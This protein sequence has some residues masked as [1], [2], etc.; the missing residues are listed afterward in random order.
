[1][2]LKPTA[3][4]VPV[5]AFGAACAVALGAA[6]RC[7]VAA[8]PLI[9]ADPARPS[10]IAIVDGSTYLYSSRTGAGLMDVA[11][12]AFV[13]HGPRTATKVGLSF[14]YIDA[15]GTVLGVD[16]LYPTGKFP[17]DRRSAYSGGRGGVDT[18][19]GN[20]HPIFASG[21][22]LS[23]TFQ[24]RMGRGAPPTDVA[25]IVVSAREVVYDDG[26]A[27]RTD[28]VPQTGDHIALPA[29]APFSAAVANGP[30]IVSV[31]A[32]P[33]SP[34]DIDDAMSVGAPSRDQGTCVV[35]TNHDA[36]VAKR[37]NVALAYVDRTGTV[38]DVKTSYNT[39]TFSRGVRIDNSRGACTD[40]LGGADGDTFLYR[41]PAGEM[42][43]IGRVI[44]SPL[45]VEFADGTSWQA[46]NPLKAGDRI[47]AP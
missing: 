41:S 16:T 18:F 40:V 29:P 25:A 14:A 10:P 7:A 34:V 42:V 11:C 3:R 6:P 44:A 2:E 12:V 24:Y 36:R 9:A 20:C 13:N 15:G 21:N 30:P 28:Q 26:T 43:P 46:P 5:L 37:V 8:P 19:N 22:A 4:L 39:G 1:M 27:W 35:F 32:V 17:V 38:V 33:G 45:L 31:R 47:T 23:S